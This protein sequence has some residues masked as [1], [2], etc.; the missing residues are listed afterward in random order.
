M[1]LG[2]LWVVDGN[3]WYSERIVREIID[4]C[5]NAKET[6]ENNSL[7]DDILNLLDYKGSEGYN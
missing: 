3:I 6:N 2:D 1:I 4:L 5:E 7:V